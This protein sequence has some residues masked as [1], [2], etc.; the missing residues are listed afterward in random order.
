MYVSNRPYQPELP[1]YNQALGPSEATYV[2]PPPFNMPGVTARVFPLQ[3]SINILHRFYK[4]YLNV[5]PGF[6]FTPALPCVLL[7][8][9]DYGHSDLAAS[10]LGWVSQHEVFF[11]APLAMWR[12]DRRGRRIFVKWVLNVP[13]IVVDNP[14]SLTTG[15]EVYGWPKVLAQLQYDPERWLTDPR[16]P[17][18]LLTLNVRGMSSAFPDTRLLDLEQQPGQ[19]PS[20]VPPALGLIDPFVWLSRLLGN[21]LSIGFDLTQL[22]LGFPLAG[23]DPLIVRD[24]GW[25]LSDS[26]GRLVRFLENPGLDVV[27]LKQFR[28]SEDPTQICYQALVESRLSINHFNRGGLLGLYNVL[29]GDL[30]GGFRIYISEDAGFPIVESLGLVTLEERTIGGNLYAVLAPFL[31]FWG[32]VDLTYGKGETLCWRMRGEPWYRGTAPMSPSS[33]RTSRAPYNT[34]AGAAQQEWYG[35]FFIPEGRIDV[36]PLQADPEKLQSFLTRF[37]SL[38]SGEG[39][40]KPLP[41]SFQLVGEHVYMFVSENRMF[42]AARSG[43]WIQ[44]AQICFAIPVLLSWPDGRQEVVAAM[45]FAFVNNPTLAMT[46]REVQGVPAMDA[47][48]MTPPRFWQP[49]APLLVM[50]LNV[51]DELGAGLGCQLQTVLEILPGFSPVEGGF[52]GPLDRPVALSRLALK[53]FRD[54]EQPNHACYQALVREPW[55][56]SMLE[57]IVPLAQDTTVRISW[58]PSLPIVETLGLRTASLQAPPEQDVEG[59]VAEILI[60]DHPFTIRSTIHIGLGD[61]LFQAGGRLPWSPVPSHRVP[62]YRVGTPRRHEEGEVENLLDLHKRRSPDSDI[63]RDGLHPW[64]RALSRPAGSPPAAGA[65]GERGGEKPA[66]AGRRSRTATK[67]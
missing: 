51:F 44:A 25:V 7:W 19:N 63:L 15:R 67:S 65:E 36:F 64:L 14:S 52:Q 13:F 61:V 46:M 42:S 27:N 12:R 58:Y 17:L 55:I 47:T 23:Y 1:F 26:F 31:P 24:R 2:V 60:P 33:S 8:V 30:T 54:A 40:E 22:L 21:F 50:Q 34:I 29:Q 38:G 18:R 35:P 41:I 20:L 48:I 57:S 39:I 3:A 43:A 56:F 32:D 62:H 5:A 6:E 66:S 45:P 28:D 4:N 49:E 9:L 11:S 37:L 10:N 53:Q 16:N 59:T